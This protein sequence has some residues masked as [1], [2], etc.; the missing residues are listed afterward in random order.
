[1]LCEGEY[2]QE[3]GAGKEGWFKKYTQVKKRQEP[4]GGNCGEEEEGKG[5]MLT[6]C[7][8]LVDAGCLDFCDSESALGTDSTPLVLKPWHHAT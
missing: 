6:C 8:R 3:G 1:M 4:L 5:W 7:V 2:K